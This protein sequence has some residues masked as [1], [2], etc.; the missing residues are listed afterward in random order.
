MDAAV[1]KQ[2][3]K[4]TTLGHCKDGFLTLETPEYLSVNFYTRHKNKTKTFY[5]N[6]MWSPKYMILPKLHVF[7]R[8]GSMDKKLE[9]MGWF[10]DWIMESWKIS[11]WRLID[12]NRFL[13]SSGFMMLRKRLSKCLVLERVAR[14]SRKSNDLH[15]CNWWLYWIVKL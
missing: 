15:W 10:I 9:F 14:Q 4:N 8:H 5:A 7:R 11:D 6:L 2:H 3:S 13:K 12:W 1:S